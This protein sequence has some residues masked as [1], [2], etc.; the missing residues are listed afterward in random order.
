MP[1][2]IYVVTFAVPATYFVEILRGIV[3]RDA[4]FQDL[5]PHVIG[6]AICGV[7]ILA[8]SL[9]RFRKQLT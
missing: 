4:D 1:F 7:V 6:L 3:L 2:P 8:L 5:L 9:A